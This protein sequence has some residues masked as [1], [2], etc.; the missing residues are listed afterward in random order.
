MGG[1]K[2][3]TITAAAIEQLR[4]FRVLKTYHC[5]PAV[6]AAAAALLAA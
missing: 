5:S 2:Q 3:E 4:G 1:C 6:V